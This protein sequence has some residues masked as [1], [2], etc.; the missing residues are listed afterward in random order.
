M[1][2]QQVLTGQIRDMKGSGLFAFLAFHFMSSNGPSSIKPV[3]LQVWVCP[4]IAL[5]GDYRDYRILSCTSTGYK[6]IHQ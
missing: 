2:S 5:P 6:I 3:R 4:K 1:Q